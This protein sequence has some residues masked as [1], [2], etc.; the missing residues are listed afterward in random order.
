MPD[1]KRPARAQQS[2]GS[3]RLSVSNTSPAA[4]CAAQGD[5]AVHTTAAT[6]SHTAE[7]RLSDPR[8]AAASALTGSA[9]AQRQT[10]S[11]RSLRAAGHSGLPVPVGP[12]LKL[13]AARGTLPVRSMF[14]WQPKS[15][16]SSLSY[17]TSLSR[18]PAPFFYLH[19]KAHFLFTTLF[20][21]FV[22]VSLIKSN[23][24]HSFSELL[25]F[26]QN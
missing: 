22:D 17:T 15:N 26:L 11:W 9:H 6:S 4:L 1:A 25:A 14:P 8:S 12:W 7:R 24:S 21:L 5:E 3:E 20:C 2:H 10:C 18:R 16:Q 23:S 19:R 13:T